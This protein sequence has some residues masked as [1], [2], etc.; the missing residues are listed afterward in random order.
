MSSLS[1]AMVGLTDDTV[2]WLQSLSRK[3]TNNY[4]PRSSQELAEDAATKIYNLQQESPETFNQIDAI[5]LYEA[6]RQAEAGDLDIGLMDPA[7]FLEATPDINEAYSPEILRKK[8]QELEDIYG[9]GINWNTSPYL[10]YKVNPDGSIQILGHEGRNRN[11]FVQSLGFPEQFVEFIPGKGYP[12]QPLLR[13]LPPDTLIRNEETEKRMGVLG[14][15]IKLLSVVGV[16]PLLTSG[17][18]E[19]KQ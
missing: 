15:V 14:D 17:E 8:R 4:E 19:D 2:R 18:E 9:D 1:R 3:Y 10:K 11:S 16:A 6:L 5:K 7:K 13:D 12:P